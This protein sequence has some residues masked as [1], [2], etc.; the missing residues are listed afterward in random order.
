MAPLLQPS[1]SKHFYTPVWKHKN[2]KYI[3]KS[4]KNSN[5]FFFLM[6]A[7]RC[8]IGQGARQYGQG[9]APSEICLTGTLVCCSSLPPMRPLLPRPDGHLPQLQLPFWLPPEPHVHLPLLREQR[10]QRRRRRRHAARW[11]RPGGRRA[12]HLLPV[13]PVPAGELD[14]LLL[15]RLPEV[16]LDE[17][18]RQRRLAV[19]HEGGSS[20][21]ERLGGVLLLWVHRGAGSAGGPNFCIY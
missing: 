8:V 6:R 3:L 1:A 21:G 14:A 9:A 4:K 2:S 13:P 7:G 17:V 19:R 20:G 5:F 16:R 12:H 11:R 18:L 15:V 10:R